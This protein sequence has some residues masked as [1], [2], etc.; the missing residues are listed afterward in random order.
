MSLVE[1]LHR[2][3]LE[4]GLRFAQ[5]AMRHLESQVPLPKIIKPA[6]KPKPVSAD[7]F[8]VWPKKIRS[9]YRVDKPYERA[10]CMAMLDYEPSQEVAFDHGRVEEIQRLVCEHYGISMAEI[11]SKRR[12]ARLTFA[13]HVAVYLCRQL[14][15]K[16]YPELGR[17]FGGLDH[18]TQIHATKRVEKMLKDDENLRASVEMLTLQLGGE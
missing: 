12:L 10:W 14:T 7:T 3:H 15:S 2:Q 9:R 1:T 6:P 4:R 13:R 5:A 11:V 17:R 16:S 18:S 8:R